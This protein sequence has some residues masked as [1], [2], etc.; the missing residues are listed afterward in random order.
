[1]FSET[2]RK[3]AALEPPPSLDCDQTSSLVFGYSL[4]NLLKTVTFKLYY[5]F[6]FIPNIFNVSRCIQSSYKGLTG[7]IEFNNE[8]YRSV[9]GLQVYEIREGG[10]I[11]VASY[12]STQ[13]LNVT[14]QHHVEV[15]YDADSMKNKTFVVIISLVSKHWFLLHFNGRSYKLDF[16]QSHMGC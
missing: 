5:I 15:V 7:N 3:L 14:R 10:I 12:N 4:V 16:R 2:L 1:M 11:N 6:I 9:F 13:G 8:G